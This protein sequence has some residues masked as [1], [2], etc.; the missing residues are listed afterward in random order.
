MAFEVT[1]NIKKLEP[2][3]G[4][5]GSL[6]NRVDLTNFRNI[7]VQEPHHRRPGHTR[8]ANPSGAHRPVAETQDAARARGVKCAK[9][10]TPQFPHPVCVNPDCWSANDFEDYEFSDKAGKIL[11][12]TGDMLSASWTARGVRACAF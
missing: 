8:E 3:M 11:M 4:V 2:R 6:A 9:C 7:P 12:F 1:E 5:A 10:G